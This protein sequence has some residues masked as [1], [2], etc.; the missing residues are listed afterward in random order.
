MAANISDKTVD[1]TRYSSAM[2][3]KC[4]RCGMNRFLSEFYKN[5]T[6]MCTRCELMIADETCRKITN[7]KNDRA[8]EDQV[9]LFGK[10]Y[11]P[12]EENE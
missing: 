5:D 8:E 4:P 6:G 11:I 12:R 2:Y 10:T 1:I 9:M 7:N 3:K